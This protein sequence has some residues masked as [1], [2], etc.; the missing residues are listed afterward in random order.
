MCDLRGSRTK[1]ALRTNSSKDNGC[2]CKNHGSWA[3]ETLFLS[4]CANALNVAKHPI[5]NESHP[6]TSNNSRDNLN[7][8]HDAGRNFHIMANLQ[9]CNKENS[10]RTCHVSNCL[11]D[12]IG[13]RP[14]RKYVTSNKFIHHFYA[15]LLAVGGLENG[16]RD[17]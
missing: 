1:E 17:R 8:E 15:N 3:Y 9:V 6:D 12:G 14:P 16:E 11:E 7:N 4:G 2:S 10:L 5:L 13:N